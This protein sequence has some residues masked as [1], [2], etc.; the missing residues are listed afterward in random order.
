MSGAKEQLLLN[1]VFVCFSLLTSLVVQIE[2]LTGVCVYAD[3]NF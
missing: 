2:H 1:G 3:D